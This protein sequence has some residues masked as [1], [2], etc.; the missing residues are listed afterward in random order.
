M[1]GCDL[2]SR[3]ALEVYIWPFVAFDEI[4]GQLSDKSVGSQKHLASNLPIFLDFVVD[5]LIRTWT[6]KRTE[7]NQAVRIHRRRSWTADCKD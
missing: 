7:I 4:R 3:T 5:M 6:H 2:G 1:F